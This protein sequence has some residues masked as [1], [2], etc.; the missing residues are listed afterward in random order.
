MLSKA[1]KRFTLFVGI[2]DFLFLFL[3]S[4]KGIESTQS[5]RPEKLI[6]DSCDKCEADL[7]QG[8]SKKKQSFCSRYKLGFDSLF[9]NVMQLGNKHLC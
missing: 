8:V 6:P 7:R 3:L 4:C 1:F 2:A 5:H 9:E